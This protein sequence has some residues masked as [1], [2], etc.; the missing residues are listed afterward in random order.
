MYP[1]V[2][3][4]IGVIPDSSTDE[5]RIPKSWILDSTRE[6]FTNMWRENRNSTNGTLRL[7]RLVSKSNIF[8]AMLMEQSLSYCISGFYG[9]SLLTKGVLSSVN[10]PQKYPRHT[11]RAYV[12]NL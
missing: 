7:Q 12:C 5:F 1:K 2:R 11:L 6:N 8:L 10:Q 4:L 9:E 3:S